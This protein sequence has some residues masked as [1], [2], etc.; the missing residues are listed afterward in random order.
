MSFVHY[1]IPFDSDPAAAA[2]VDQAQTGMSK[3]QTA[4]QAITDAIG[5]KQGATAAAAGGPLKG[6]TAVKAALDKIKA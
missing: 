1:L 3:A 2:A 6:L 5:A 4:L